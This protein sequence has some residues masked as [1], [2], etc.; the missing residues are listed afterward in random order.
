[1]SWPKGDLERCF[2]EQGQKIAPISKTLRI[3]NSHVELVDIGNT[4]LKVSQFLCH[5]MIS[6][7]YRFRELR[8]PWP[9]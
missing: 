2:G 7:L 5:V 9:G 8:G 1:M 6:I 3:S 4:I